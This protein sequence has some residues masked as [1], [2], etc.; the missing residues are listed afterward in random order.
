[1]PRGQPAGQRLAETLRGAAAPHARTA[2]GGCAHRDPCGRRPRDEG[3]PLPRRLVQRH[4]PFARLRLRDARRTG[5][6]SRRPVHVPRHAGRPR[7]LRHRTFLPRPY[8]A[9]SVSAFRFSRPQRLRPRRGQHRRR[10]AGGFP[11]RP[12]HRERA[13]R[14]GRQRAAVEHRG[15]AA[16]PSGPH[17][18]CRRNE[19]QPRQPHGRE[20]Y[21]HP[22][23]R[24]PPDRRRERLHAV[25]GHP[26]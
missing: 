7:S 18:G 3:E 9:L 23:S 12:R 4:A 25:R 10:R 19:D 14:A 21:G 22:H 11:R 8:G 5:R 24:Q 20:L 26:R 6:R 13:G 2:S 15:R 1:M 16:R 17:D